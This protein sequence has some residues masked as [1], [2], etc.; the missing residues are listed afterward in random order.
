VAHLIRFP[1][2]PRRTLGTNTGH[3]AQTLRLLFDEVEHRLPEAPHQPL[4]ID[5]ADA[6]DHSRSE[7]PFDALKRCRRAG[8]EER[9]TE[10]L[11]VN[12]VVHPGAAH[13][14][15][16]A[17]ADG[18]GDIAEGLEQAKGLGDIDS[19]EQRHCIGRSGLRVHLTPPDRGVKEGVRSCRPDP[20]A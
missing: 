4:G 13:L 12:A 6:A 1:A 8:L 5:R 20:A 15:E 7:I 18:K 19:L 2:T 16:L 3:L 17:G 9:R 14:D 10:L 11:T